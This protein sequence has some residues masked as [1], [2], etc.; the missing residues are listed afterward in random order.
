MMILLTREII[1]LPRLKT[2]ATLLKMQAIRRA[3]SRNGR[4][5]YWVETSPLPD[6]RGS[7]WRPGLLHGTGTP[8]LQGRAL[9]YT[10][11]THLPLTFT[12]FPRTR[13]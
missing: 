11:I 12:A 4:A 6:G 10:R 9:M 5:W 1:V 13:F 2:W 3:F 8:I 7:V